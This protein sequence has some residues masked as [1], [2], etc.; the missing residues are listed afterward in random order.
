MIQAITSTWRGRVSAQLAS[1]YREPILMG[2][3]ALMIGAIGGIGAIVFRDL[4]NVFYGIFHAGGIKASPLRIVIPAVG[5]TL[6]GFITHYFAKEV[7]GHGVPQILESLALRGGKIRP[8]VAFFGILAPALTIGAGGSVGREGPIALIGGA[9]GS[10]LGQA[11]RLSDKYTSL[12]LACGSAAGIAATFNA[13]IAGGFFGLEVILGSYSMGAIMPI[14]L[15]A[16]TGAT[17]FDAIMGSQPPLQTAPFHV[18]HPIALLFM[19]VLGGIAGFIGLAY[20]RGLTWVEDVFHNWTVPFWVKSTLGGLA[21]GALGLL[22]PQ[23]LGVGY[24]GIHAALSGQL[25][26]GLLLV[27]FLSKYIATLTTVGSGGSGGVFAP[28]LFLG[29]MVGGAFGEGLQKIVPG[30]IPHP[31]IYAIAGM[32]AIFAA[33]AQAPFVAIT[34]L[35]EVTGD[36]QLTPVVMAAC[37]TAYVVHGV[38]SRDSMYTV[39]LARRG[40]RILSGNEVRPTERI[41]VSTA[42]EPLEASIEL[43]DSV[44]KAFHVLTLSR[45]HETVVIDA[46]GR[47]AGVLSL[48]DL[49]EKLDQGELTAPIADL[50][51]AST[52]TVR[53]DQNLEDALRLFSLHDTDLLP[54]VDTTRQTVV[55]VLTQR[56][57]VRSY[58]AST[59]HSTTLNARVRQV[60]REMHEPGQFTS[61][62]LTPQSEA[63]GKTLA[64]LRLQ[65]GAVLVSI[66][67]GGEVVAPNGQTRLE[68][69]D[70][71]LLF[72]LPVSITEQVLR[73][74]RG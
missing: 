66:E 71:V 49:R 29:S 28:S 14:F 27:L 35:L 37:V 36:Y 74:F 5:L 6:V 17:V 22:F 11:L 16:V 46:Q 47:L 15:S 53:P 41:R 39:K 73:V 69:G 54:V 26:I 32:G 33:A 62:R 8:R 4:I 67:R 63:A 18:M 25:A 34:I 70:E 20:S 24:A 38:L 19:I 50:L 58:N 45:D 9:F 55:G 52:P 72:I 21:V 42:M 3:L 64:D 23:V 51:S 2:I 43:S 1:P 65:R 57:V 59:L 40:I 7:K 60:Q 13:P 68:V 48:A 44:E 56:D 30:L 31:Q 61:V 12:L 10:I